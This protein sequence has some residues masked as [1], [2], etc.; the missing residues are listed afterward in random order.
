MA[1]E[2]VF[3]L[4]QDGEPIAQRL[5]DTINVI[6]EKNAGESAQVGHG[7]L[8]G[9]QPSCSIVEDIANPR[10]PMLEQRRNEPALDLGGAPATV[11]GGAIKNGPH[12]HKDD[13]TEYNRG[14]DTP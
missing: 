6:V 7:R 1:L 10:T 8:P 5:L 13:G 2:E 12:V 4:T 3:E 9:D 14:G 11:S